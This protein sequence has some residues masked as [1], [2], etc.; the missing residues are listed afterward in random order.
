MLHIVNKIL[1][2]V[3]WG[4]QRAPIYMHCTIITAINC[5][6]LIGNLING[7]MLSVRCGVLFTIYKAFNFDQYWECKW[8]VV[9]QSDCVCMGTNGWCAAYVPAFICVCAVCLAH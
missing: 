9:C 7:Q 3:K 5:G 8:S 2:L 1:S 6:K 4:M